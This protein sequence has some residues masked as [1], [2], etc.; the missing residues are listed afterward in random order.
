MSTIKHTIGNNSSYDND[1]N[2]VEKYVQYYKNPEDGFLSEILYHHYMAAILSYWNDL[3]ILLRTKDISKHIDLRLINDNDKK[4]TERLDNII[5][6]FDSIDLKFRELIK[7]LGSKFNKEKII[8]I[9]IFISEINCLNNKINSYPH[10]T[11]RLFPVVN[12]T[13]LFSINTWLYAFFEGVDLAGFSSKESYFDS[14]Q[15]CSNNLFFHDIEH[16]KFTIRPIRNSNN[17][18]LMRRIYYNILNNPYLSQLNKELHVLVLWLIIHELYT[19]FDFFNN[20][21]YLIRLFIEWGSKNRYQLQEFKKFGDI[22]L[23][24]DNIT[25]TLNYDTKEFYISQPFI[26]GNEFNKDDDQYDND[27][28]GILNTRR[29]LMDERQYTLLGVSYVIYDITNSYNYYINPLEE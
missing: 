20:P 1:M 25:R 11:S 24:N 29:D 15:G 8:N 6:N 21:V 3:K 7:D 12:G 10:D 23:K 14:E 19:D 28:V 27:L 16:I 5:N 22:T 9:F 4:R 18:I 26:D 2:I 13:G 17:F